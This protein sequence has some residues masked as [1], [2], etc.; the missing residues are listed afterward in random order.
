MHKAQLPTRRSNAVP[1]AAFAPSLS[2]EKLAAWR[3]TVENLPEDLPKR[4]QV[5]DAMRRLLACVEAWWELPESTRTKDAKRWAFIKANSGGA[6][7]EADEIPLEDEHVDALWE[8]TPFMEET[9][10]LASP[11][12]ATEKGLF[13]EI[14]A[15]KVKDVAFGLLWFVRE[16]ALDREPMTQDKLKDV[17]G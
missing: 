16:I 3:E 6:R 17:G 12:P 13:H 10:Y 11:E 5:E 7:Q 15:G 4:D 9:Y 14:P 2:D 1:V 8:V